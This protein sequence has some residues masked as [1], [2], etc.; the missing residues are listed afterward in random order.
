MGCILQWGYK[1]LN[2]ILLKCLILLGLEGS[3]GIPGEPGKPGNQGK[4]GKPGMPGKPGEKVSHDLCYLENY[5][6][7]LLSSI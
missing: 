7:A 3:P 6:S 5:G 1:V 4:D 2:N